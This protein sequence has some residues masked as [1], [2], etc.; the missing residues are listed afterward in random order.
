MKTQGVKSLLFKYW[1]PP[2]LALIGGLA[3]GAVYANEPP[4]AD[5][6]SVSTVEDTV[7]SITL[8]GSDLDG[9]NLTYSIS[10]SPSHGFLDVTTIPNLT[11]TPQADYNG[12]D[13]FSFIVNDGTVDS[14][15]AAI[16]ITIT[17]VNDPPE[18]TV[19]SNRIDLEDAGSVNV[20]G[21]ATGISPGPSDESGQVVSFTIDSNDNSGLFSAGPTVNASG[22]LSYTLAADANGVANIAIYASD[23][24]GVANGGDDRS[25][26][27]FFSITVTAV[28]DPPSFTAGSSPVVDED[29]TSTTVTGWATNISPGPADEGGQNV[30]FVF[31]SNNNPSLFS[32]GPAVNS[33]GNLTYTLVNNANGVANL[34][35]KAMDNGGTA[36]GGNDSSASAPFSITVNPINDPP[37]ASSQSVNIDEDVPTPITLTGSDPENDPLT[38]TVVAQPLTGTL[39]GTAPNLT[40]T[41]ALNF[42]GMDSFSYKVNDGEFDSVTRFIDIEV[43][44]VND[45]PTADPKFTTTDE[46]DPVI[47]TMSGSDQEGDSLTFQ[48]STQPSDGSVSINGNQA[49]YTPDSFYNG[50]DS[51]TYVANDGADLSAPA[52]VNI[53]IT[54]VNDAPFPTDDSIT[55]EQ[56]ATA[57]VLD[58]DATSLL[59]NDSD[60]EGDPMTVTTTPVTPPSHGT[61]TLFGDGTFSY[62]HD[63][64]LILGDSF[65]YEVCDNF[66]ACSTATVNVFISLGADGVCT[67]PDVEIPD[68]DSVNGV[69]STI[70]FASTGDL[71]TV[72]VQVLIEHT[73]V[74]DL[75]LTLSHDGTP[76]RL[77]ERP[78]RPTFTAGCSGHDVDAIF[79]D[80]GTTTANDMCLSSSDI[81]VIAGNVIPIDPFINFQGIESSGAWTLKVT[82]SNRFDIGTLVSWCLI[83]IVNPPGNTA[84]TANAQSVSTDEETP[85]GITL[86]GS[87]PQS[88]PLTYRVNTAPVNGSL[89]G[90]APNLTYTPDL[91]FAGTDSFTFTV[92]DGYLTSSEA[93]VSITVNN[94]NDAP[95][96]QDDSITVTKGGATSILNGGA[97]SLLDN[98]TDVEGNS[99]TVNTTP[100]SDPVNGSLTLNSNGTFTYTHGDSFTP[101]DSFIYEVCDSGSPSECATA[102]ANIWVDLSVSPKCGA[103]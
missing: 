62:T 79:D 1:Q 61:V 40:Y 102:E 41:S 14:A 23:N 74:G 36:N 19:G 3:A 90:N 71:A 31:T 59:A 53:T 8:T 10:S 103:G 4:V 73:W 99:L 9:D 15:P 16:D 49:T 7:K 63:N 35:V 101:T 27:Q 44:S 91:N 82:D 83:A 100:I 66:A 72:A 45:A 78:G 21:W 47:I 13:S 28:N 65:V 54:P 52:T 34:Q 26:D 87:D 84:P 92:K 5:P 77:M 51:F 86:S 68:D 6:Q 85:L 37:V 30:S 89:S 57:T 69:T 88:D 11:Y 56:G 96:P 17:A 12:S 75:T 50:S 38:Y 64:S 42:S 93:T 81:P 95:S 29:E 24:G 46:D 33:S 18:F 43:L 22:N 48:I 94:I 70:N 60:V 32:A 25:D 58:S 97:L 76:V 67:M 80:D 55:L 2:A 98:D 39:S 20:P